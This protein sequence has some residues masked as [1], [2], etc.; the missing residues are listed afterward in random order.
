MEN[1]NFWKRVKILIKQSGY[2]QRG[3]SEQLGLSET[4]IEKYMNRNTLPDVEL[5]FKIAEKLNTSVEYLISG[6]ESDV[7]KKKYEM[8]KQAIEKVIEEN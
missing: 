6:A 4:S 5:G 8:L 7:Y 3:F 2:T 1:E